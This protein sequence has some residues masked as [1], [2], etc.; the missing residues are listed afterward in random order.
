MALPAPSKSERIAVVDPSKEKQS[1]IELRFE[2]IDCATY[3]IRGRTDDKEAVVEQDEEL[4]KQSMKPSVRI[5]SPHSSRNGDTSHRSSAANAIRPLSPVRRHCDVGDT[6]AADSLSPPADAEDDG[7]TDEARHVRTSSRVSGS[8]DRLSA[9]DVVSLSRVVCVLSIDV[10]GML[11][12]C[13]GMFIISDYDQTL[14]LE[15]QNDAFRF[16]VPQ[17]ARFLG[18]LAEVKAKFFVEV[19]CLKLWRQGESMSAVLF[20]QHCF[21]SYRVEAMNLVGLNIKV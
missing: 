10:P 1:D 21:V 9:G 4:H 15:R 7:N 3:E 20:S 13:K 2:D 19:C 16:Q 17:S 5:Q 12:G 18:S 8:I 14:C 11:R 6:T